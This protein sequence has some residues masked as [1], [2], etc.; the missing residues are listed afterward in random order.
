MRKIIFL[1]IILFFTFTL[2]S[3]D[4]TSKGMNN[5]ITGSIKKEPGDWYINL[6]YN[7][8]NIEGDFQRQ[9]FVNLPVNTY[10]LN[11]TINKIKYK[12]N[13]SQKIP[14]FGNN[15]YDVDIFSTSNTGFKGNIKTSHQKSYRKDIFD[16]DLNDKVIDK[17]LTGYIEFMRKKGNK[18][19]SL[20]LDDQDITG[21]MMQKS[22]YQSEYSLRFGDKSIKG[23]IDNKR[24]E[25]IFNFQT[26]D[27][28]NDQIFIF[29][30]FEVYLLI[31]DYTENGP[32]TYSPDVDFII[33]N[34][35]DE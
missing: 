26:S 18:I 9:A 23:T 21:S 14:V 33:K 24:P 35:Q 8:K 30:F 29:L 19:F 31:D 20:K 17:N 2:F 10:P 28:T 11:V 34:P 13:I 15:F 7:E 12:G 5:T 25:Y 22:I 32:N 4:K 1:M 6:K 27:L 16:I 3:Q